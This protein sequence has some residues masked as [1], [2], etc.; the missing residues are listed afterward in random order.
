MHIGVGVIITL[1]VARSVMKHTNTMYGA[2]NRLTRPAALQPCQPRGRAECHCTFHPRPNITA[3]EPGLRGVTTMA[4]EWLLDLL[5]CSHQL[6]VPGLCGGEG[7]LGSLS[8]CTEE[9]SIY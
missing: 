1:I 4:A 8:F 9:Q 2:T 7:F 3:W 6:L 5:I